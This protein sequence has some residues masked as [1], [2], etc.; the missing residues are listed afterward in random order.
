MR[1][2]LRNFIA[3]FFHL[4]VSLIVPTEAT[5]LPIMTKFHTKFTLLDI[6]PPIRL[7]RM[8][9][10]G[11]IAALSASIND[12]F[13][14]SIRHRSQQLGL[15]YSTTWKILRKDL[16]VK[17]FKI[18]QVQELKPI[19]LPQQRIFGEWTLGKFAKIKKWIFEK[20]CLAPWIRK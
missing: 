20:L 17:A 8:W 18:K 1:A 16:G 11:N 12:D 9:I 19:G 13:Q 14:F 7:H 3:P 4:M 5:I 10:E 2:L 6:K 15:C